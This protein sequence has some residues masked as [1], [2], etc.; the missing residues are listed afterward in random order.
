MA[1]PHFQFA[2]ALS[3]APATSDAIEA[4][5]SQVR[6]QLEGPVD[7]AVMFFTPHHRERLDVVRK[8]MK[9]T[10][11][12]RVLLGVTA[13]G[14]I[15]VTKELETSP[16]ISL[17]AA[18]LPGVSLTPFT[19]KE[20]EPAIN[21]G[22]EAIVKAMS[23][24]GQPLRAVVLMADPYST[25]ITAMI[26]ALTQSLP[27][28]PLIGGMASAARQSGGNRL[29][30]NDTIT[31][32]GA[33]G[34]AIS[35]NVRVDCTVS[36][37][38]RPIGRPMVIT[39]AQRNLI[40][41]LGGKPALDVARQTI[42]ELS[43]E[44]R[45][46]LEASGMFVGR[47]INEYKQ[48]F[49]RGDF[50]IRGVAGVDPNAGYIAIGDTQVRVGQTV[51]FHVRDQK[52]A[53]ED[54]SLLLEAQKLHGNTGGG[55]LFSCNGRGTHLFTE[56]NVDANMIHEALGDLPLAGCFAAGEIGPVGDQNF[57]HGHTASFAVL[58]AM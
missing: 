12:P 29:M 36:Q 35:G 40:M 9:A 7:L 2:S 19:M 42:A 31:T 18:R 33:I 24:H 54:F 22:P 21:A 37:G 39:K 16:G 41:E 38:C 23:P 4:V 26:T 49:G 45:H 3:D 27:G 55:L 47:V 43:Q 14:V 25:P 46:L 56:P 15:G 20:L 6:G 5:T 57:L 17:L 28:V 53:R 10:L 44:D 32:S 48:R 1:V 51:Q 34:L 13:G 30:L 50:L 52:A 58:R 11:Q 8:A